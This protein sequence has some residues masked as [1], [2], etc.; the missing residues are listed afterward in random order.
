LIDENTRVNLLKL[1]ADENYFVQTEA[2]LTSLFQRKRHCLKMRKQRLN[3]IPLP[4]NPLINHKIQTNKIG[5][6]QPSG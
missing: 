5:G 6:F 2:A 3:S 4:T 1:N